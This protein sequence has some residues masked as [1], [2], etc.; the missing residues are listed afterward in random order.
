LKERGEQ[1][2]LVHIF[3]AMEVCASYR[4]WHDK[5]TGKTYLK[6]DSSKCMTYY[7]YFIDQQLGLCYVRVPTWYPFR[8]QFYF[9]GHNWLANQL[10]ERGIAYEMLDNAFVHIADYAVVR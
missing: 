10:K 5:V 2:G 8:L 7:F 1:P 4:P 6:P 9:N 3:G